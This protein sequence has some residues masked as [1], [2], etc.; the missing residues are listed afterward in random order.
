MSRPRPI[1]QLADL[2][3]VLTGPA[4]GQTRT[5]AITVD[6]LPFASGSPTPISSKDAKKA[7]AVNSTLLRA[8]TRRRIPATGFVIEQTAE[9]LG[10][11]ASTNI[12]AEWTKPGFDLG[13]H[14]YSH[15]DGNGLSVEQ[16]EGEIVR[17]EKTIAPLLA[18]ASRKPGF[19][20]FPYNHTGDTQ[21]KH[22]AVAAFIAARGYQWPP[23]RSTPP[24]TSSMRPMFWPARAMM[25]GKRQKSAPLILLTPERRSISTRL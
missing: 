22:D 13:N 23:I 11:E 14:L 9:S 2:L 20:R 8:F 24:T 12:L 5:V 25:P 19:L 1:L 15:P 16:I 17:G 6:D 7:A 4:L 10:F 3:T 18:Q 21:E